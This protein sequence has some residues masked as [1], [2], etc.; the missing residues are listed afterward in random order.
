MDMLRSEGFED[1]I[2]F[3]YL[4]MNLRNAMNFGYAFVS[5]V[6]AQSTLQCREKLQGFNRWIEPSEKRMEIEWS[7][8]QGL[9]AHIERYRNSPLMHESVQ[10][11]LKPA[12]FKRGVRIAFPE[13][14]KAIR[15]PRLRKSGDRSHQNNQSPQSERTDL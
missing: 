1:Y 9:E 3:M 2:D 10:D 6:S 5:F 4:P 13:P 15:A 8:T 7:E 12:L 11:E 14:T